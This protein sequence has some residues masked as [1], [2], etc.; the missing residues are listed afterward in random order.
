MEKSD[1]NNDSNEYDLIGNYNANENSFQKF[2]Q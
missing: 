2:N 1:E